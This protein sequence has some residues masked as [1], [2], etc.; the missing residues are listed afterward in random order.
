[1]INTHLL[2]ENQNLKDAARELIIPPSRLKFEAQIHES[3]LENVQ[4]TIVKA[5]LEPISIV[6]GFREIIFFQFVLNSYQT[7]FANG[8]PAI[9]S[10]DSQPVQK[11]QE[12]DKP[13]D[14]DV[15]MLTADITVDPL[16]ISLADD[17]GVVQQMLF[18]IV[19]TKLYAKANMAILQDEHIRE[20]LKDKKDYMNIHSEFLMEAFF[21]NHF[22]SEFEPWIENWGMA[23]EILQPGA[24]FGKKNKCNSHQNAKS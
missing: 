1:M 8:F 12:I 2:A 7:Y 24:D 16:E 9:S 13:K 5:F 22:V 3:V 19:L 20:S 14:Y 23:I 15:K 10:G 4:N 18:K 11:I 17:T 6:V 21:F